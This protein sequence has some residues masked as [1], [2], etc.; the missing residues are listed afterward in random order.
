M[1]VLGICGSHRRDG[2]TLFFLKKALEACEKQGMETE[3]IA[4]SDKRIGHCVACDRCRSGLDC[5]RNDDMKDIYLKL[6]KAG[7]IIVASPVYFGM[8]SGRLKDFF[9]RTLPLRRNGMMLSGKVGGAI[10]VGASRNGGQE[11]VCGQIHGWMLLHEMI[12]VADKGTAH[13]GGTGWAPRDSDP[14]DDEAGIAT[15]ENLGAKVCE[16]LARLKR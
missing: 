4:L 11:M 12:V 3:A 15:C 10:A 14:Y 7:A 6:A 8:V 1:K 16:T 13:F 9:D 2:A 5:S